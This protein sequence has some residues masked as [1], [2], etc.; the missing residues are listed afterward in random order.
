MPLKDFQFNCP[1]YLAQRFWLM[2]T[3]NGET[4]G[5]VLREFMV[6]EISKADPAF[7][8][9]LKTET[10]RDAWAVIKGNPK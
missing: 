10:G 5:T 8:L 7:E 1:D 4:P 6:R 2:C 9:D 3:E